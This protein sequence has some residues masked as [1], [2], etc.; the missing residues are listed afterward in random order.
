MSRL[1]KTSRRVAAGCGLAL[2]LFTTSGCSRER[3]E[4]TSS[5]RQVAETTSFVRQMPPDRQFS[6]FLKSYSELKPNPKFENTLSFVTSDPNKSIHR[7]IAVIVDPVVVYVAT[8]VDPKTLPDNGRAA[9]A[10]YFQQAITRAVQDAFPVVKEPGPLVLRLRSAIIGVDVG[11][12]NTQTGKDGT[13]R[14]VNIGKVGVE[15]ELLDSET[16]EQIAAAV[17]R[18]NLGE[19]AVVDSVHFSREEKFRAAAEAFDGWAARL[20]AFLDSAHELSAEDS[21][22]AERSYQPYGGR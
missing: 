1:R 22:R 15:V 11:P 13:F 3:V 20:R 19:G 12:G 8:K 10:D 17:D 5:V 2:L 21:A 4:T 9:V 18:K 7:Y 16:G 6:G 14:P